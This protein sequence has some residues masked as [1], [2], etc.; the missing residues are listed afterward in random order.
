MTNLC[1]DD[2]Y[3]LPPECL[4]S[5][6]SLHWE[7]EAWLSPLISAQ[8]NVLDLVRLPKRLSCTYNISIV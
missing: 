6:I 8:S 3:D 4:Y 5:F 2:T 7:G 1:D